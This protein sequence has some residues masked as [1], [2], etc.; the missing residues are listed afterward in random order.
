MTFCQPGRYVGK[1]LYNRIVM[2]IEES[3]KTADDVGLVVRTILDRYEVEN[4]LM[5]ITL[6]THYAKGE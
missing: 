5:E 1:T 6:I 4:T 2:E 3:L